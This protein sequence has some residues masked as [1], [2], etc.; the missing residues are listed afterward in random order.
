MLP[1][2]S[3]A[4][5]T[6]PNRLS[7]TDTLHQ[8]ASSERLYSEP[9]SHYQSTTESLNIQPTSALNEMMSTTSLAVESTT[10]AGTCIVFLGCNISR[11]LTFSVIE[12]S[13]FNDRYVD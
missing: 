8:T 10:Q 7:S 1:N 3:D 9:E 13:P 12:I 6:E 4:F 11:G 5:Y 2:N